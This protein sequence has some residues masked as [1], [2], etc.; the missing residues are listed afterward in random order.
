MSDGEG[1]KYAD[2]AEVTLS[3]DTTLYAQWTPSTLTVE[4]IAN[5][6]YTGAAITPAVTVKDRNETLTLNTDYT[7]EYKDNTNVGTATVTVTGKGNY[8]NSN[9]VDKTFKITPKPLTVTA[10]AKTKRQG[11]DDP[12][13]TYLVEGL[14]EG[15]T[16][17][18]KLS[19]EPGEEPG[20]YKITKGSL[21]AGS[22]YNMKF[23]GATLTIQEPDVDVD[24]EGT[25][26]GDAKIT[27]QIEGS[28]VQG[29]DTQS[30]KSQMKAVAAADDTPVKDNQS[31]DVTV[32][33]EVEA[34]APDK[35][36]SDAKAAIESIAAK[37]VSA[38]EEASAH[39]D[40][41]DISVAKRVVIIDNATQK[42]EDAKVTNLSSLGSV[43]D[44]PIRYDLT[45]RY[46]AV[47]MRYHDGK[48]E[49]FIK[50]SAEP[51]AL[52]DATYRIDG[53]GK[54]AIVHIYTDRFSTYAL[55]TYG[56]R[57]Y[58]DEDEYEDEAEI[59]GPVA[60]TLIYNGKAQKLVKAGKATGGTMQYA[61]G[62]NAKIAPEDGW[63]TKIPTGTKAGT[64][65][66]WY[67]VVGDKN[68]NDVDPACI[69]VTIQVKADYTLL[70]KMQR[71]GKTAVKVSWT[72]VA[73]ADGY[74]VYFAK[75]GQKC[76]LKKTVKSGT[77]TSYTIKGLK[78]NAN[79]KAYVRAWKK[80]DGKKTNIG[81]ASPVVHTLT[82]NGYTGSRANV[83]SVAVKQAKVTLSKG[84]SSTIKASLKLVKSGRKALGHTVN[85]R[86]FSSNC[87][88]ATVSAKGK[89]K[90]VGKGSCT[91]YVLA[92]NGERTGVKVT[93]K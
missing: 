76:A 91:I 10:E 82:G 84:K 85:Y 62:D 78:K 70:A 27:G 50:L 16:L 80:V 9:T 61:L 64:Y 15:D 63:S 77:T 23:V 17:S 53:S 71:S 57:E 6:V 86:Y 36:Q 45:D 93:V 44:I 74:D 43:V 65:Y 59:I 55:M 60:D 88:V 52:K 12:A 37:A 21:S 67:R 8:V 26:A 58:E 34:I 79:Y 47:V 49:A 38:S 30:V 40:F 22:N 25:A 4:D 7:V 56:D 54:D 42:E 28:G 31:K 48:A 2:K 90:A 5:Q 41:L 19:R 89:I 46:N 3:A 92:V 20:T 39:T 24:E 68:H 51:T 75:C 83:K 87:A 66:V 72:K 18:G 33:L 14:V 69:E 73:G 11:K 35:V 81:K 32:T 1:T 13:L 29:M